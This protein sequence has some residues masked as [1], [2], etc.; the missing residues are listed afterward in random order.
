MNELISFFENN[1]DF[2][3]LNGTS[4][5]DLLIAEHDLNLKFAKDYCDIVLKYG[6]VSVSGHEFTGVVDYE[7]L[8]VV[9]ETI[10]LRNTCEN[11]PSNMYVVENLG[12]DSIYILQNSEG[13][14]FEFGRDTRLKKIADSLLKYI[15]DSID[16]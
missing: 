4:M 13:E 15:T 10:K 1:D 3:H 7:N 6:A 14:I 2:F 5:E 9:C 12:I 11:M 16:V 8:S